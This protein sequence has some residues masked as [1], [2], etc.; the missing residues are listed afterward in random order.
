MV[1]VQKSWKGR[2]QIVW[3]ELKHKKWMEQFLQDDAGEVSKSQIIQDIVDHMK[4]SE[5]NVETKMCLPLIAIHPMTLVFSFFLFSYSYDMIL[6]SLSPSNHSF[7]EL[8]IFLVYCLE[9]EPSKK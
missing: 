7:L 4:E 1:Y 9:A 5:T 3:K 2:Y 8:K 6:R